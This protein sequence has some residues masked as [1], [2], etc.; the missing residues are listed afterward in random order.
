[1]QSEIHAI[2]DDICTVRDLFPGEHLVDVNWFI[3]LNLKP[4]S[5]YKCIKLDLL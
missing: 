2:E 4:M 3:K 1:M 5:L